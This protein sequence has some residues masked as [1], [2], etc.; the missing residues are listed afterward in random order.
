LQFVVWTIVGVVTFVRLVFLS[1]PAAIDDLPK[2]PDNF[3]QLM[4]ISSAGYLGG[5]LARKSGPTLSAVSATLTAD[6][7]EL[8]LTGSGLS[9]AA[10]FSIAGKLVPPA[11]IVGDK[12]ALP[13]IVQPDPTSS[14]QGFARVLK[15]TIPIPDP[16]WL[17]KDIPLTIT[18]LDGQKAIWRY[19]TFVESA[20]L[21]SAMGTL[22]IQGGPFDANTTVTCAVR[23]GAAAAPTGLGITAD[24]IT[25]KVAGL[26]R[27]DSVTVTVTNATG[28]KATLKITAA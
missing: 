17:G 25:G 6:G 20:A 8:T 22:T 23:T 21:D 16:S 1:D 11:N 28:D 3:L 18:N 9:Q 5:K 4:A 13:E 15:F 12:T 24:T 10:T 2:I 7:L 19:D 14:E 27:G 26:N